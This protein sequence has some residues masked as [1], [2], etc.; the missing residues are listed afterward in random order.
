MAC[1]GYDQ[2]DQAT[3]PPSL[4]SAVQVDAGGIH[5]CAV[6]A[7]NTVTC[8]GADFDDQSSP[9]VGLAV[10]AQVTAG[11]E[12]TCA[13]KTDGT[14]VCWG[15]DDDDQASVPDGLASVFQIS[16]GDIHTCAFKTDGTVVCW[17]NDDDDQSTVPDGLNLGD[18][19]T[20][21]PDDPVDT[22]DELRD[23]IADMD[24]PNKINS[25]L[26]NELKKID[27]AKNL[28][29]SCRSLDSFAKKVND[30]LKRGELNA[31]QATELLA[32]GTAIKAN[33]GCP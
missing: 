9:P 14:V 10:V 26:L 20:P 24:L 21:P 28:T 15:N 25:S 27:K 18:P 2:Y 3:V 19:T 7:D 33:F 12:H 6:L 1:W 22:M 29:G 13:L 5:T 8:W 30:H 16:A 23:L 31:G 4:P 17:G 32:A 11:D